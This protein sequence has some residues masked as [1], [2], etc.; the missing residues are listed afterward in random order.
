M[1]INAGYVAVVVVILLIMVYFLNKLYLFYSGMILNAIHTCNKVCV[2]HISEIEGNVH[3]LVGQDL[4]EGLHIKL[5]Q[6]L[7]PGMELFV[8][9]LTLSVSFLQ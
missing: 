6:A 4:A 3:T 5:F 2:V 9:R 7:Q 8:G 1:I